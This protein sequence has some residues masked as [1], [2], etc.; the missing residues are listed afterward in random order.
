M[1]DKQEKDKKK[2]W[3]AEVLLLTDGLNAVQL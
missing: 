3:P 2:S 1:L